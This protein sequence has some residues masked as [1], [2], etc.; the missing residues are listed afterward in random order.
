MLEQ[1]DNLFNILN[2]LDEGMGVN[3]ISHF[4]DDDRNGWNLELVDEASIRMLQRDVEAA[5]SNAIAIQD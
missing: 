4:W 3:Y 2:V 5:Y 1:F